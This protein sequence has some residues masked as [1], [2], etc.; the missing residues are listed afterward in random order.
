MDEVVVSKFEL[1]NDIYIIDLTR[2]PAVPSIFD[3]VRA[4]DRSMSIFLRRFLE[5]FAKPIKKGG[6]EHIEYVPTQVVTEYCKYNVSKAGEL[7]KGFMYPSS[8]NKGGTSYCLFFDRYD[9]GVKKKNTAKC[10]VQ[11]LKLVKGST[12]RGPVKALCT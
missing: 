7:I 6:R 2:L 10:C 8:V 4:R 12:K 5:D 1:L 9:C 3:N 11:Y